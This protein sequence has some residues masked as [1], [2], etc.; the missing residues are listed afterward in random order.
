M[1]RHIGEE[2]VESVSKCPKTYLQI[3][4]IFLHSLL[5]E[6]S[7]IPIFLSTNVE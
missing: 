3:N 6:L 7:L 5:E 1:G 2:F 4:N